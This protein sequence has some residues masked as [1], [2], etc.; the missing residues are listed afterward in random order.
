[1]DLTKLTASVRRN[2]TIVDGNIRFGTPKTG[3]GRLVGLSADA[4]EALRQWRRLQ[5]E[6]R[7]RWG[8]AWMDTGLVFT[9]ENGEPLNPHSVSSRFRDLVGRQSL[10]R[11]RL[12][13]ARHTWQRWP[14]RTAFR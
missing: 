11:I 3:V 1:M 10:P 7:L 8:E 6:E 5:L 9:R 14:S 4:A 2:V 12:H 13:D